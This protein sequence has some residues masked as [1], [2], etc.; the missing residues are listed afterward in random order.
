MDKWTY[1]ELIDRLKNT[2]PV[3]E[4]PEELTQSITAILEH[5]PVRPLQKR[6]LYRNAI[7]SG[8]AACGLFCL[9]ISEINRP[10]PDLRSTFPA[11][12]AS[13]RGISTHTSDYSVSE[14]RAFFSAILQKK[15]AGRE[16]KEAF[17]RKFTQL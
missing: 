12:I 10:L 15:E 9:L 6:R 7:L 14:K 8:I 11:S 1:D 16:K 17:R 13:N 4:N 3:L 5:L 2:S